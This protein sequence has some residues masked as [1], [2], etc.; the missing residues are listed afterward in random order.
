MCI[1][2]QFTWTANGTGFSGLYIT[3]YMVVF[4]ILRYDYIWTCFIPSLQ[5]V[6]VTATVPYIV[7]LI[8]LVRGVTLPGAGEG[9]KYYVTPVWDRLFDVGV[10][11]VRQWL[12]IHV[13]GAL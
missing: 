1:L 3:V 7:L 5:V 9:I 13:N 12:T 4:L 10:S 2:N 8:L 11:S 6:W